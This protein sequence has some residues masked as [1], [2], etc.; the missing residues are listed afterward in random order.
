MSPK[1]NNN[2]IPWLEITAGHEC[3]G[4]TFQSIF[5][6]ILKPV[7]FTCSQVWILY[8]CRTSP[9]DECT[10]LCKIWR[11]YRKYTHPQGMSSKLSRLG[12]VIANTFYNNPSGQIPSHNL[13]VRYHLWRSVLSMI[14]S[15]YKLKVILKTL[16]HRWCPT[17]K[18]W[19][20]IPVQSQ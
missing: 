16:L 14:F 15:F 10:F 7:H 8:Y 6:P 5:S 20:E 17:I 18:L 1:Q 9:V 13:M 4:E 3:G 2:N 12:S 19:H 11:L